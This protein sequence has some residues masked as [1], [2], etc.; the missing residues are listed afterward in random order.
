MYGFMQGVTK[1]LS[2]WPGQVYSC[3]RQADLPGNLP[4]GQVKLSSRLLKCTHLVTSHYDIS[5]SLEDD[6]F[7]P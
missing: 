3:A 7:Y 5:S 4:E 2:A 1:P 6:C